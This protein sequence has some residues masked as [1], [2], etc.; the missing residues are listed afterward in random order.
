MF[1]KLFRGLFTGLGALTGYGIF[2]LCN[3]IMEFFELGSKFELSNIQEHLVIAALVIIFGL[4]F[5]RLTPMIGKQGNK[6]ADN[7]ATDL[8]KVSTNNL[9]MGTV[10]L[11]VGLLIAFLASRVYAGILP[12]AFEIILNVISYLLLG[13]IGI[14]VATKSGTDIHT[15]ISNAKKTTGTKNKGKNDATPKIFDTSVIIDGRIADIMKTGFIEGPIVIPEFV[16]VELRHIADS[17]DSLKRN[18]GRRGL[19]ILNKIQNEYGIEIYNTTSEKA[20]D[21]IPEV[22]V[23]LLKLAQIM[24]G[25]VVTNDFNLNKV[26]SIKG[27][28]VLNINELANTLKPVVLPGEDMQLFLVKEGKERNQAV[29]YL[30]DGTM[31]VVEDGRKHIG[32]NINVQVT[33]VLQTAAGRM[34]FARPNL[35]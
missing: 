16:L 7:I 18:R 33:S 13:Y 25:K 19:D 22:D 20:L 34:I 32:N 30:D 4:I 5:F 27:V 2:L 3:F 29:A 6:F 35:R 9:L 24:H 14:V 28:D 21:E 31:I 8:Q 12:A 10:G 11:L 1:R 23:K 26:A 17:S 15:L